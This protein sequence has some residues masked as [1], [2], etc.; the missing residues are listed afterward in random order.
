MLAMLAGPAGAQ[1]IQ[2]QSAPA[3]APQAREPAG[4]A[5]A[6]EKR[7]P[8]D[9]VGAEKEQSPLDSG[10]EAYRRRDFA[11]ALDLW[12]PLA[13]EGD[14]VAQY[15]IGVT[16]SFEDASKWLHRAADGGKLSGQAFLGEL[17]LQGE[18]WLQ[19]YVQAYMWL[20]IAAARGSKNA[21]AK[22]DSLVDRMT[23]E[24]LA[25]AQMMTRKWMERSVK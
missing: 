9:P 17:F 11:T 16:R 3:S 21:Q 8:A 7:Q 18:G 19:D 1:E 13:D 4:P 25:E 14:T 2:E 10:L 22:R 24:Q 23:R 20:N 15:N 12:R 6:E 5:R